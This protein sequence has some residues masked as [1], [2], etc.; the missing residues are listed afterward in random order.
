MLSLIY[1]YFLPDKSIY[2]S[3]L[4]GMGVFIIGNYYYSAATKIF[5]QKF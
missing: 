2:P 4:E 5:V 3:T 1:F